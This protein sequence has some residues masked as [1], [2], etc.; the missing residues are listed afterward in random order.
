L[1]PGDVVSIGESNLV[2]GED[3]DGP[4]DSTPAYSPPFP[5]RPAGDQQTHV[6]RAPSSE[7]E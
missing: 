7:D 4:P 6:G 5:P 3:P 2:Y 1:R